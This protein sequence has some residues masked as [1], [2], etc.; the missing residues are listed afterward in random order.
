MFRLFCCKNDLYALYDNLFA[1]NLDH[2]V[3]QPLA[4]RSQQSLCLQANDYQSCI[5]AGTVEQIR[6]ANC[7]SAVMT[8]RALEEKKMERAKHRQHLTV[9]AIKS[10]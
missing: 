8:F 4:T 5:T 10:A 9:P 3:R 2:L 1:N 7:D 6:G